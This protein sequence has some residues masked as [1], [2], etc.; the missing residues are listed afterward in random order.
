MAN[1]ILNKKCDIAQWGTILCLIIALL[2]CIMFAPQSRVLKPR[3]PGVAPAPSI[4]TGL[5]YGF[6]DKQLAYYSLALT[7]QNMGDLGGHIT[8][9]KDYDMKNVAQWL[10][11]TYAFDKKSRYAPTLAGYYFGATQEP[12]ELRPIIS[13][14]RIAGNSSE[15]EL[16]RYLAQAV[17][18]ARF[19]LKDQTLA[20]DLAYQLAALDGPD[21]PMWTKQ[22]P[23][24]VM[25]NVGDKQASRDLF[26]TLM[27][28]SKNISRQELNFMCGYIHDNLREKNDGIDDNAVW[29]AFCK[30][31]RF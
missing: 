23:A 25:S 6:G 28:T 19:Q 3:W 22:M 8:P 14:L 16:W 31:K 2:M 24:F 7:L 12:S 26:L 9:I 1:I 10:R 15:N 27:A 18:L 21:M 5:L 30:G 4:A 17:Y 13:Y 20:L 29:K 11:L